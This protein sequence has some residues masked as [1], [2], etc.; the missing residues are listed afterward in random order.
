MVDQLEKICWHC[1][2]DNSHYVVTLEVINDLKRK[3][4]KSSFDNINERLNVG[5]EIAAITEE[6]LHEVLD[7]AE[8]NNYISAKSY[9]KS[10]SYKVNDDYMDGECAACGSL[11]ADSMKILYADLETAKED[12][13][14]SL[15]ND[16]FDIFQLLVEDVTS[17][18]ESL[19]QIKKLMIDNTK[20]MQEN[21]S[22]VLK[23]QE[24]D[25]HINSLTE[26]IQNLQKSN[27]MQNITDNNTS[28]SF[29]QNDEWN[30]V[31]ARKGVNSIRNKNMNLPLPL[32][33]RFS[34][35]T[36]EDDEDF[37]SFNNRVYNDDVKIITNSHVKKNS[38][39]GL[40]A[41]KSQNYRD[42]NSDRRRPQ[43]VISNRN[44]TEKPSYTKENN[45]SKTVPG[46]SS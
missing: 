27:T 43:V 14:D 10:I 22:C 5:N 42:S 8:K 12:V 1:Y 3:K 37:D 11:I 29:Y 6:T 15:D 36:V 9:R 25:T 46:N 45:T 17:L 2:G 18:K 24:K 21:H 35:L 26:I 32:T 40:T 19:N 4:I 28:S 20:L 16:Y 38:I 31:N 33:N 23:L 39:T 7:F 30:V 13:D 41:G 44:S 34:R